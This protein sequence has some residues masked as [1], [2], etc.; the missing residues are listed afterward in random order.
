M[1]Y[2]NIFILNQI[3]IFL[4][5]S[6]AFIKIY[7]VENKKH[8]FDYLVALLFYS[9]YS[10]FLNVGIFYAQK[11]LFQQLSVISVMIITLSTLEIGY[12]LSRLIIPNKNKNPEYEFFLVTFVYTSGAVLLLLFATFLYLFFI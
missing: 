1:L 4:R 12:R 8:L 9:I 10:V 3:Y 5:V 2:Q 7:K 6:I 11:L